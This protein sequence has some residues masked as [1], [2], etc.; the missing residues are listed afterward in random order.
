MARLRIR[1]TGRCTSAEVSRYLQQ[2]RVCVLPYIHGLR[3]SG[4]AA[5][6]VQH[7]L[8]V[9]G[10][11]VDRSENIPGVWPLRLPLEKAQLR[12]AIDTLLTDEAAHKR[13]VAEPDEAQVS[14][15]WETISDK[16][17]SLCYAGNRGIVRAENK[18]DSGFK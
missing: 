18:V 4:V 9:I 6:C 5:T 14:S 3:S 10:T 7:R 16:F 11:V 12:T 15:S 17:M 1:F 13:L 2:M 8:P